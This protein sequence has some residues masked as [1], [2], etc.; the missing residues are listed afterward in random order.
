MTEHIAF[1]LLF[2]SLQVRKENII[3]YIFEASSRNFSN[4]EPDL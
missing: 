2:S 1:T 4:Y 3:S